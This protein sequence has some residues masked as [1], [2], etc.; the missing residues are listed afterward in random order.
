M[1]GFNNPLSD[2]STENYLTQAVLID[3]DETLHT[4]RQQ[5]A[6]LKAESEKLEQQKKTTGL[7]DPTAGVFSPIVGT[8]SSAAGTLS[9]YAEQFLLT[10]PLERLS[11]VA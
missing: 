1:L 9:K 6:T 10:S 7:E 3:S 11:I 5:V 2:F 8:S 4:R